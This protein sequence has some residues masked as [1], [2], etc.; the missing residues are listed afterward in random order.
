MIKIKVPATSANIGPGFDTLGV[1]LNLFNTI[2]VE[3]TESTQRSVLWKNG[4]I[5]VA[6]EENYVKV[7]LD[8]ILAQYGFDQIGYK[9]I[10]GD[11]QIPI[12][13]GLGSSAASIIAGIYAANYLMDFKLSK[14]DIIQH[15]T[16]IEGHPDN[17]VPAIL[18]GMVISCIDEASHKIIHSTVQFPD[19]LHFKVF[20]PDFRVSTKDARK[21]LPKEYSLAQCVNNI[22]RVSMLINALNTKDYD[23]LR[24][25]FKDEIHEPYRIKLI[26]QADLIME[27]FKSLNTLGAFISGAGPTLI[28][29]VKADDT[30]FDA[31]INPFLETLQHTWTLKSLTVNNNG[32]T[33]EILE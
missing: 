33:Y 23:L 28:S 20:I 12:S 8:Q 21:V 26:H 16:E 25:S 10:I 6:D 30:E 13:R 1:A 2:T 15:A 31:I 24:F 9:L 4:V 27:K 32:T 3:K 17:V 22:S 19:E 7:T 11:C 14:E 18:G 5:E 29:L